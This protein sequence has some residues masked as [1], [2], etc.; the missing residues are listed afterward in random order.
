M[1]NKKGWIKLYKEKAHDLY[2]S[3]NIH[4]YNNHSKV[5]KLTRHVSPMEKLKNAHKIFVG[6]LE[7]KRLLAKPRNRWKKLTI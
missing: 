5:A 6:T 3:H 4:Y 2:S 7:G 1:V